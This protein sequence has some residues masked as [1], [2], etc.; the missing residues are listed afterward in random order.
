MRVTYHSKVN[1][2]VSAIAL[3]HESQGA[4]LGERFLDAFEAAIERIRR[5]PESCGVV[6][7]TIR[8]GT[9]PPFQYGIYYR[10]LSDRVR[11]LVVKHHARDPDYGIRRR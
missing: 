11:V 3:Y 9:V 4:G 2:E 7:G 6:R 8:C 1:A 5:W 10:I